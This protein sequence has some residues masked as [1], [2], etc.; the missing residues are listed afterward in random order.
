MLAGGL[1]RAQPDPVAG[2]HVT[3][4]QPRQSADPEWGPCP[5]IGGTEAVPSEDA[6]ASCCFVRDTLEEPRT[7]PVLQGTL[8][9][10]SLVP[11]RRP[12]H[13]HLTHAPHTRFTPSS[14]SRVTGARWALAGSPA[15]PVPRSSGP[16]LKQQDTHLFFPDSPVSVSSRGRGPWP[17]VP[18]ATPLSLPSVCPSASTS[19]FQRLPRARTVLQAG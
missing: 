10:R 15:R 11:Q 2:L 18:S 3:A 6:S 19:I 1:G 4:P 7:L 5:S 13:T 9:P 12:C 17:T 16:G 8:H 14:T